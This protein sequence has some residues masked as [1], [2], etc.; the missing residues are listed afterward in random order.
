MTLGL[1]TYV[2]MDEYAAHERNNMSD[3]PRTDAQIIQFGDGPAKYVYASFADELERENAKLRKD[4]E[5]LE[6]LLGDGGTIYT[7]RGL[8]YISLSGHEDYRADI[9]AAMK[10]ESL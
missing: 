3:T 1:D 10:G 5:R 2:I 9:D 7:N 6:W 8:G 4:K